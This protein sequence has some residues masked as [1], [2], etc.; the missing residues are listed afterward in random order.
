MF[1]EPLVY[2]NALYTCHMT[3]PQVLLFFY[4]KFLKFFHEC[5]ATCSASLRELN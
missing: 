1:F 2:N 5:A 4:M 3:N